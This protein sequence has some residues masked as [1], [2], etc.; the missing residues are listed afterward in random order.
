[1][2]K[3]IRRLALFSLT[4]F[5]VLLLNATWLQA[6]Q[7]EE[8]RT[9]PMNTR[10][11]AERLTQH[12]GPI[13]VGN[14]EI[15]YSEQIKGD[16]EQFQRHYE[17]GE[18]YSSVIGTFTPSGA[19]GIER[20]ENSY[21]DGSDQ[22]LAVGN[23]IDDLTGKERKG[24]SVEL[25]INP[26]A[27][28]A[29]MDG[30]NQLGD[31]GAAVALNPKTGA[32]LA[33]VS[34]PT[35]D[36]NDVVSLKN[37]EQASQNWTDLQESEQQPLLN[38][39]FQQVY[40]PGSTFKVV[41]ASA[42]LENGATPDS[43]QPAPE[44]LNLGAPLNNYDHKPCNGGS[45]D[46]LKHSI[47]ISCNTSMAN[48]ALELGGDKMQEQ[49]EAYGFNQ[50]PPQVPNS[51]AES[52]YPH[53]SAKGIL[54]RSGIGQGNVQATPL[55]MA[56]VA[57]GIANDGDVMKPHL[58]KSVKDSDLSTVESA[59][60]E[61]Y[62]EATSAKTAE[63]VTQMMLGVTESDGSGPK[64]AVPGVPTAGKTG[65]AETGGSKGTHNWFISFAPADDP[66]IA[67]AVVIEHGGGSGGTLAAPV[68]RQI[69]EAVIKE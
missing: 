6:F 67:V 42:A 26:E 12:R 23:F 22:R 1:M 15:A 18:L 7:A 61:V 21:L 64:G 16:S 10:K 41:T 2:N 50:E 58:V 31:N 55:Q 34:K 56:M 11:Y 38:R 27:Q 48:W 25:T 37:T 68:S 59:D 3:S 45:P 66:Q 33:S 63:D 20:S 36:P 29:A 19:T 69:M 52:K 4:L 43:T 49:A 30:L 44:S 65:T 14:E 35:Y 32:I 9:S 24:A 47:K 60:P 46:S 62:S 51:V 39:A 13:I 40:P 28:Q 54:G 57:G 8:L 53:E 17:N 5:G